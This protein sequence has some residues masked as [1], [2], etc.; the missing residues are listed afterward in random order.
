MPTAP[1]VTAA[2]LGAWLVK[3]DPAGGAVARLAR[4]GFRDVS[5]RCVRASYRTRLVRA[6]QPVLLW[7]SGADARHPAGI[8]AAGR[9]TGPVED[10]PDGL[11]VPV[12]LRVVDPYVPRAALLA[13][14][15][16][17]GLEVLRFAAGS[18]PSYLDVTQYAALRTV[19]PQVDQ[20]DRPGGRTA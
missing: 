20:G 1:A 18:N 16:L 4:D 12:E 6:G 8:H 7:V 2:S 15:R 3:A 17:A 19:F 10:G 13:D 5:T 9:T 11:V 14:P